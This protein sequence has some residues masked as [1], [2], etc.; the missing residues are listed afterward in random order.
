V[1]IANQALMTDTLIPALEA[2]SPGSGAY[3]NEGNFQQQDFQQVFYGDK[4]LELLVMN[5]YDPGHIFYG[6]TAVG[7]EFWVEEDDGR[8][9]RV[10]S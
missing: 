6:L 1:N 10:S 4:Y 2:V 7:S 3:L 8:L 5:K 9:C